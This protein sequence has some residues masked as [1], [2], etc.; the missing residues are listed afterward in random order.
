MAQMEGQTSTQMTFDS[1]YNELAWATAA[2]VAEPES[3]LN[4]EAA[5]TGTGAVADSQTQSGTGTF[6]GPDPTQPPRQTGTGAADDEEEGDATESDGEGALV[7]STSS[8]FA[9]QMTAVPFM[10]GAAAVFM[11]GVAAL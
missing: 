4:Y 7:S 3:I 11:A 5:L 10:A 9:A 8:G 6:G 2:V 1:D